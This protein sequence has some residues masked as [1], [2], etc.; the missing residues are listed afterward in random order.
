MAV[1]TAMVAR[2]LPNKDDAAKDFGIM[3]VANSLPQ[4]IVPAIGPLLLSI[5]GWNFFSYSLRLCRL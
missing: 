1:D 2:V 3:N 4:S 5:G